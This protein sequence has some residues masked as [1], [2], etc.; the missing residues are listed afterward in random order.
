MLILSC[1]AAAWHTPLLRIISAGKKVT[2]YGAQQTGNYSTCCALDLVRTVRM[3]VCRVSTI[4]RC[5]R[6]L[7]G[8]TFGGGF[9]GEL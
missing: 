6:L 3:L 7:T 2:M 4:N 1:T 8:P 9:G 5:N